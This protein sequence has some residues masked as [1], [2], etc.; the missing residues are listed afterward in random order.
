LELLVLN[1]FIL[2]NHKLSKDLIPALALL[3]KGLKRK[4]LFGNLK[5]RKQISLLGA[6]KII[7]PES[8]FASIICP[9]VR[10]KINFFETIIDNSITIQ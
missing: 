4:S 3:E 5:N 10:P 7:G 2:D 6:E 8:Y 9:S 1:P